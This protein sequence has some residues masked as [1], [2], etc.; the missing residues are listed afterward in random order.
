MERM[1]ITKFIVTPDQKV[2]LYAKG[3]RY[4]DMILFD[5]SDL[6]EAGI[7][8]QDLTPG[9]EYACRFW[10]VFE[11]SDKLNQSGNPYRDVVAL[12]AVDKPATSTSVDNSAILAEL[13][14]IHRLLE[15]AL[16]EGKPPASHERQSDPSGAVV[17]GMVGNPSPSMVE[18]PDATGDHYSPSTTAGLQDEVKSTYDGI[19][20]AEAKSRFYAL[21]GPAIREGKVHPT[22]VNGLASEAKATSAWPAALGKLEGA[23]NAA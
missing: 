11:L 4:R 3:H 5:L 15:L 16:F 21:A 6:A 14:A 2:D 8:Y 9:K 19:P 7:P 12:E 10:A 17:T 1:L 20:D 18:P 23:I 13:R 22:A